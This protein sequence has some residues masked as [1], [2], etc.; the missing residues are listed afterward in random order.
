[1]LA[2]PPP[3]KETTMKKPATKR[4]TSSPRAEYDF[5]AGVRGKYAQRYERGTNVVLLDPEVARAFPDSES[6]NA[7]LSALLAIAARTGTRKRSS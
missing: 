2:L 5:S 6:V 1:M 4:T 7:A 3:V